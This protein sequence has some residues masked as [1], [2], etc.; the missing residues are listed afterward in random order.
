MKIFSIILTVVVAV[1][2]LFIAFEDVGEVWAEKGPA[3]EAASNYFDEIPEDNNIIAQDAFLEKIL[4]GEELFVL[5][6]RS[7]EDYAE[8]HVKRAINM[9]WGKVIS[10]NLD[11]LPADETIYIYC[12]S[13]QTAGQ[14][15]ALLKIAGFDAK[16]VRF[17]WNFGISK[18]DVFDEA[19][20]ST[21]NEF[22]E[23]VSL[24]IVPEIKSAIIQYF[25]ELED[26]SDTIYKNYI[27][28]AEDASK[29]LDD[30][31]VMFLSIRKAEDYAAGHIEGA[32]NIPWGKGMQENFKVLPKDKKIIVYCYSGQTAGQTIAAMRVMGYDTVSISGGIGVEANN[33][34]GW[35]NSGYDLVP[36][37]ESEPA[38]ES[39]GGCG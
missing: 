3:L 22:K 5:D 13:G 17:G 20:E 21:V 27:I 33:P 15:V 19:T 9:P 23:V 29:L 7:A 6:I 11:K 4:A 18:A 36:S 34:L 14:A 1:V 31:S 32:I 24:D 28:S 8:S 2:L 25:E 16:S 30:D 12:Y 39:G 26:L 10:D 38:Q 37:E 35:A